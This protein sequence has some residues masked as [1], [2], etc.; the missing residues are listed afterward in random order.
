MSQRAGSVALKKGEPVAVIVV[1][2]FV[3][4]RE[5]M[6]TTQRL[7]RAPERRIGALFFSFAFETLR[8]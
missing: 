3:E 1:V 4:E 8:A 2:V 5:T 7:V 6:T